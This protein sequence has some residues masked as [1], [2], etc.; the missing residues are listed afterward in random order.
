MEPNFQDEWASKI[1]EHAEKVTESLKKRAEELFEWE[2]QIEA[3]QQTIED[4]SKKIG[5]QAKKLIEVESLRKTMEIK[6]KSLKK[7]EEELVKR[8]TELAE[9]HKLRV[10]ELEENHTA[11]EQER[12]K[13]KPELDRLEKSLAE[14]EAKIIEQ[15]NNLST[16]LAKQQAKLT[17]ELMEKKKNAIEEFRKWTAAQETEWDSKLKCLLSEHEQNLSTMREDVRAEAKRI[18]DAERQRVLKETE[19]EI[20]QKREELQSKEAKL[21]EAQE[22]LNRDQDQLKIEKTLYARKKAAL[23]KEIKETA[24]AETAA[25]KSQLD[26]YKLAHEDTLARLREKIE[27]LNEY[28]QIKAAWGNNPPQEMERRI[29]SLEEQ[30]KR[31]MED[32]ASRPNDIDLEQIKSLNDANEKLK[33]EVRHLRKERDNLE[34]H[35][36]ETENAQIK[37][38]QRERKIETLNEVIYE[39]ENLNAVLRNKLERLR[40]DDG[41]K[42][43]REKRIEKIE[44]KLEDVKAPAVSEN[45]TV[46]EINET[47]WLNQIAANCEEFGFK[48]PTRILYAFH[49]AL[50][51][52]DWSTITVL[53]GV[54]GTGKSEL[55][56]LYARFGGLNYISVP[57]Q[58][59]WDSQESMLGFFNSIDNEFDAQPLLR[60]LAQCSSKSDNMDRSLNVVL[61]D[62]MNLAHVEHYF[63]EFLSKLE[64]RRDYGDEKIPKI[65]IKLGAGMEPY[66]LSLTRNILWTGTMNQDETT[67]SLSDKVLDRGIVIHFPRPKKLIGRQEKKNIDDFVAEKNIHML[68]YR[69]WKEQWSREPKFIDEQAR[70]MLTYKGIIEDINNYM[71]KAGRALGHRVWQS[72]EYYIAN[73]PSVIQEQRAIEERGDKGTLTEDLKKA[74][75]VA[76]EDQLVQKVMPKLRGIETIGDTG[77]ECLDPIGR[78]LE[79]NNFKLGE[80]F[81]QACSYGYGQFIWNSADYINEDESNGDNNPPQ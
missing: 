40:T 37:L 22:K 41:R 35:N 6:E 75:H 7:R 21:T 44:K 1:M 26:E 55:P 62:E 66:R 10:E 2:K 23:D 43:E 71:A 47:E 68:D 29:H 69:V 58:P 50:K 76:F 24:A 14:R 42:E 5:E 81:R 28:E 67:K 15:E 49:T 79:E 57:V 45:D 48:F 56:H 17:R 78:L 31:L 32:L 52:S 25:L 39:L 12:A 46:E 30:N 38:Q 27:E 63:A 9:M 4:L 53:A 61:L 34:S 20:K 3:K 80:D 8:E 11:W 19:D 60:F 72:I 54:S 51:I 18:L 16:D 13:K 65:D 77:K 73:Y 33:N 74:M 36:A 59:N 70:Q 64:Q